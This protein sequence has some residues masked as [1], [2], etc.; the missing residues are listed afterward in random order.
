MKIE[1]Y[2][3]TLPESIL[4]GEDVQL[5]D[6][7]FRDIFKFV[8]LGSDDVFYHLGCGNGTGLLIATEEFG[9]KKV[10]GIDN[11]K[12]K[13]SAAEKMLVAKGKTDVKIICNDVINTKIDD[14]TVILF[15]FTDENVLEKMMEK[16]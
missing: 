15:W 16:F 11:S 4:S 7:T 8:N 14:A 1:E 2:L 10:I 5:P 6:Q 13:T 12:E 3:K 9:A